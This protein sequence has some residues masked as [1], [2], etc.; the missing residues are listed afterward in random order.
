MSS[1]EG[2]ALFLSLAE[3][4]DEGVVGL[5]RVEGVVFEET[6]GTSTVSVVTK[7]VDVR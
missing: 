4:I 6:A 2:F 5:A 3:L 1:L 7:I